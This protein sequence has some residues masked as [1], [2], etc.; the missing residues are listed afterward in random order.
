MPVQIYL[1]DA[2]RNIEYDDLGNWVIPDSQI[3]KFNLTKKL[4]GYQVEAIKNAIK[5]FSIYFAENGGG[6]S[7]LYN[8]CL[9]YDMPKNELDV[10]EKNGEDINPRFTRLSNTFATKKSKGK[11]LIEEYNF[12]NRIA[13]WMA[14]ASGKTVV[15]IKLIELID[16][17]QK[18]GLLP[19][20]KIMILL[21]SEKLQHQFESAVK[22]YNSGKER[23]I[24]LTSL[25]DYEDRQNSP[26]LKLFNEIE[27][28]IYRSDLLSDQQQIKRIDTG[29]YDNN[30]EWFIFMDEAHKGDKDDS[31]R[32]D[33]ISIMSRN[34]FLFNFSATFT[35]PI[36]FDTTCF[37]FN[38]ERFIEEGYG[39]NIYL[40]ESTYKFK[41]KSDDF[42]ETQKQLQVLK[43]FITFT[44][45]KKSK[46]E[47]FYHNP[48][49]VTLVDEINTVD[50]DM[51]LFFA[52]VEKIA[53]GNIEIGLFEK[54]KNELYNELMNHKK[55]QFG[56]E[57]L[58]NELN[59]FQTSLDSLN[60]KDILECVYNSPSHGQIEVIEGEKGKEFALKLKTA[61]APFAI[62]KMG[63]AA[64]YV[65]EKLKGNYLIITSF[66][67]KHYFDSLNKPNG[68]NI[69][70]LIGSRTFYEGWDSNRPNVMNFINIG[71]GEAKK[72]VLQS[73]GRGV[74]IEPEKNNRKRLPYNN[75][76]KNQLLE[77]LF[78]FATNRKTIETILDVMKA[79]KVEETEIELVENDRIFDLLIPVYQDVKTSLP[80]SK[81]NLSKKSL[82]M[83]REYVASFSD[84]LLAVVFGLTSSMIEKLRL[85]L[86][87]SKEKEFFKIDDN[88]KYKDYKLLTKRL[89][90]YLD[91]YAKTVSGFKELNGEII[92]F[93]HIKVSNK[94]WDV[95]GPV[96]KVFAEDES[97]KNI[98]DELTKLL[99]E[100]Q[101]G[102]ISQNEYLD[103][104]KNATR[105]LSATS[106]NK[107]KDLH[108]KRIANHF[109]TPL[110]LSDVEKLDYIKHIINVDGEVQFVNEL[111]KVQGRLKNV[112]WMFSKIDQTLD[113]KDIAMPYFSTKY[114]EYKNFFPDFM[115]WR[116]D[117]KDY[118]IFLVDPKGT[119]HSSYLSKADSYMSLFEENG[120]PRVFR[121]NQYNIYVHLKLV[122]DDSEHTIPA[123]YKKYWISNDN[124]DWL[125]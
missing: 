30:G 31:V 5:V 42:D 24:V 15:L 57:E 19:K 51:D 81:F 87:S 69:N 32:Q 17:Y 70:L 45:V 1:E 94:E 76:N 8:L 122:Y 12:F 95:V 55:Y 33:Y 97:K 125:I 114:N 113:S 46:K 35:D 98:D 16:F 77:T 110:I 36:D 53:I 118:H 124:F 48:L 26:E 109:Y 79:Q 82:E 9:G 104:V 73:L 92:H 6:K 74:R 11:N 88:I 60:V 65:R 72:F 111:I 96:I 102:I 49:M 84:E 91:S 115:F 38:L 61:A 99:N 67:E 123:L 47:G 66:E 78:V 18:Q 22:D 14:T 7:S 90:L 40:S 68:Q 117:G 21:P 85:S 75:S 50:A 93:K 80:L 3:K 100:L 121:Y 120:S 105:T 103:K 59:D 37:N 23:K 116:K 89:C 108:L 101:S 86:Q 52:E 43:S 119:E 41:K 58:K 29:I 10:Y 107:V 39:K 4:Y 64:T 27:V 54:A 20:N 63:D 56:N 106:L 28:F 83:L 44:L 2:L 71:T 34:G 25:K 13:F 112:E 62:F